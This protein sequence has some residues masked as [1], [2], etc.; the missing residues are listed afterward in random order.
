MTDLTG[1]LPAV[2]SAIAVSPQNDNIRLIG[3]ANGNVLLN[4]AGTTTNIT[5]PIPARYVG[6]VAIDPT[7]ANVAY[8]SLNGY[9]LGTGEHVWKTTNLLGASVTWTVAGTGIPDV[10]VNS[11]AIDPANTQR[12]FAG[13][14]IGVF[15]SDNGGT[16]WTPFNDG[17]PRVPVFGMEF[18]PLH[19][20][21]RVATH[22]RGF[23]EYAFTGQKAPFDFDGDTKTDIGIIRPNAAIEW[24]VNRSS[25][26]QTFALQFGSNT[27]KPTPVDFTGDGKT[28]VAIWRPATGEWYVLRSEDN[29]FFA[30]PF[31][32]NG[33]TPAPADFDADGK[34]DF[35]VFRASTGTWFVRR[36]TDGQ[37]AFVPW[38]GAGDAP[39][40][41]DY[42]GDGKADVAIVR[43]NGGVREWWISRS[44]SGPLIMQ[45]GSATDKAVQADYTGDGK[46]DVAFWRPGTGDWYIVRS[47]DFS[48]FAFP[49]GAN[50]DVPA[51]GDYD[52]DAK[53]D[54]TVFRPS[55]ATWFVAR[56]T[57]GTQIVQFGANGD[58]PIPNSFV[59]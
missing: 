50:G 2:V 55:S 25:S 58:R 5:G 57:A 3:L 18:H 11:F 39:V 29:S 14:D 47:E 12:V 19:R 28:D 49:F 24:W 6:R 41:S 27:D 56:S 53:S 40:A 20:V 54:P 35:V 26:G 36:S 33:D 8:V 31:G 38:G 21:L 34:A 30:F 15:R 13:T 59:P 7:N 17:L 37:T 10:P 45:F 42:D 16:S 9:G 23:Y 43:V 1:L 51:P 32:A 46:T 22:G 44:T 48:F 52:G 4:N